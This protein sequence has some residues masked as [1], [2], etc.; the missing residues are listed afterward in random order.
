MYCDDILI[1]VCEKSPEVKSVCSFLWGNGY[2]PVS[3]QKVLFL[4]Q[5]LLTVL[6]NYFMYLFLVLKVN[7]YATA[8]KITHISVMLFI[9]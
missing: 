5:T 9:P 3:F 4:F 6:D 8:L 1:G 7:K 2:S